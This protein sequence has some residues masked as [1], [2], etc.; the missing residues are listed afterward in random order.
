MATETYVTDLVGCARCHGDG[1][2][3]IAFTPLAHPVETDGVVTATHWAPCPTTHEPILM[4]F[5]EIELPLK[6]N[7]VE[8]CHFIKHAYGLLPGDTPKFDLKDE[9]Q[10]ALRRIHGWIDMAQHDALY[11][12]RKHNEP[13]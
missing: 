3:S 9:V 1:H 5:T 10:T 8:A 4:V 11:E 13:A 12:S 2:E 7:D 6:I